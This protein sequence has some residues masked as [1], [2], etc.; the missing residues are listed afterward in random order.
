MGHGCTSTREAEQNPR[1]MSSADGPGWRFVLFCAESGE[2]VGLKQSSR[3][4]SVIMPRNQQLPSAAAGPCHTAAP[5][6]GLEHEAWQA[7]FPLMAPPHPT[8]LFTYKQV[9]H[10]RCL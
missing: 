1:S 8:P 10:P 3:S 7:V 4:V 5:Q 6:Q 2:A 9:K